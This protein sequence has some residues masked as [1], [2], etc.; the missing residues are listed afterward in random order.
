MTEIETIPIIAYSVNK[1]FKET[2]NNG[3]TK[4]AN[5]KNCIIPMEN[6][7]FSLS[8]I[9][10]RPNQTN[11]VNTPEIAII[12]INKSPEDPKK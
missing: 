8:S 7:V 1:A 3:A 5:I 2:E 4:I 12:S 6:A 9:N 10:P 11:N